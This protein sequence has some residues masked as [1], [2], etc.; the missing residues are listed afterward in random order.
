MNNEE[1][2]SLDRQNSISYVLK[3]QLHLTQ[4][5]AYASSLL[6]NTTKRP[7][8]RKLKTLAFF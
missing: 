8:L 5:F 3:L 4:Y 1:C 2:D 6:I 7:K